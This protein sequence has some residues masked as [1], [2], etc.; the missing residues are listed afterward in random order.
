M[1][2]N[3]QRK[4]LSKFSDERLHDEAEIYAFAK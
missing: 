3:F 1:M 4:Q 2:I